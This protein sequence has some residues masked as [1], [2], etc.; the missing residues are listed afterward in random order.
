MG[1]VALSGWAG[2]ATVVRTV[3]VSREDIARFAVATGTTDERHL[4]PDA[5]RAE[6]Y[7]DV[8]E[9]PLYYV[10][11]RTGAF[12]LV[13]LGEL[14]EEGTPAA[15]LPPIDFRQAMAGET[16][17]ELHR[18]IVAGDVVTCTRRVEDAYRKDGR[19]GPLT[20]IRFEYRYA[21]AADEP[22]VVEHFTRLFR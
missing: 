2:A 3:H 8:V 7:A 19:S 11:L 21:D 9:P 20:F 22:F 17:A 4:D 13:P 18:P 14:H 6:G 10:A 16:S 5:A 15:D 12:N 1:E